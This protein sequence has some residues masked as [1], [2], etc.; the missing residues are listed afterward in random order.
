[1]LFRSAS[2]IVSHRDPARTMPSTVSTSA[3]VRWLRTDDVDLDTLSMMVGLMFGDAL[4]TLARRRTEGSLPGVYGDVRFTDLMDDPV[5]A[6]RGA[7]TQIDREVTDVH[8]RA[9]PDS[10][11][12]KPRGKH[13]AHAYTAEE[14]GF[15]AQE[16]RSSM[17]VY[18]DTFGIPNEA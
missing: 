15:D 5:D 14:W 12:A 4:N 11:E 9:I 13:G 10:L 16:L 7:Y 18:L 8:A 6:I 3:M 2:V 1:M 17:A